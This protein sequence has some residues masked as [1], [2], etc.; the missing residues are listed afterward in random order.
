MFGYG[1]G[2]LE[3]LGNAVSD[4]GSVSP[5]SFDDELLHESVVELQR[6]ID[7]LLAQQARFVDE[8][9]VR[10]IWSDDGSRSPG[11]RLARE[12]GLSSRDGKFI[13]HRA[14]RLSSMPLTS[15][16]FA[17]GELSSSRVDLLVRANQPKV[18]DLFQRDEAMLL[19]AISSLSFFAAYQTIRYWSQ[20]ADEASAE[21]RAKRLVEQRS[22]NAVKTFEGSVDLRALF[23]PVNG[24]IFLDELERL[25]E[26]LFQADWSEA[27]AI[28]NDEVTVEH[29]K[30]TPS[31]RRCDALVQM[32]RRSAAL[33]SD[34]SIPRPLIS[35]IVDYQS[36]KRVCELASGTVITPGQLVPLL[37]EAD[38]ERI[39][40]DAHG[41]V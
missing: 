29:L 13:V 4:L 3:V 31:Q 35:V 25:E 17:S 34:T 39:V 22:A 27:K 1:D 24:E 8:W 32:A 40:F 26:E 12:T 15:T 9:N 2:V 19:D 33:Q 23:D 37:S 10:R 36:L 14:R 41:R 7:R 28:Y 16:A 18:R 5:R 38:I 30:R 6:L 11:S 20:C 21:S